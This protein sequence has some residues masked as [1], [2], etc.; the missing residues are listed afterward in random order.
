MR[1]ERFPRQRTES[2]FSRQSGQV[3][4]CMGLFFLIFVLL[5]VCTSL[6]IK[7]YQVTACYM[8]DALAASNL[9]SAVIDLREYGVS[10]AVR[11]ADP[12]RA[13][14]I[15]CQALQGNLNLDD[16]WQCPNK[17]LISGP[18]QIEKYIIYNV[19]GEQVQT[20]RW[21]AGGN[22]HESFGIRGDIRAPNGMVV[23]NTSV[24]SEIICPVQGI[25]D[26]EVT[27]RKCKLVDIVA[28]GNS[29]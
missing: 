19:S 27:A 21:E 13:Y 7:E 9:A 8:E 12:V 2:R 28:E 14:E 29:L 15:Y 10:H 20:Y 3:Q 16:T 23:E 18:V 22:V 1:K 6:Q 24:Y 4:W 26:M 25:F 17:S 5:L 11:I